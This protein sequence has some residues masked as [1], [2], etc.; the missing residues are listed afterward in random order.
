MQRNYPEA[1]TGLRGGGLERPALCC[2]NPQALAVGDGVT[3]SSVERHIA[4]KHRHVAVVPALAPMLRC[5]LWQRP[6]LSS[7]TALSTLTRRRRRTP[8]EYPAA[9]LAVE[10]LLH[11]R[12]RTA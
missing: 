7:V 1:S 5:C 3:S 12:S 4:A 10:L 9:E 8:S 11:R 6:L 2:I